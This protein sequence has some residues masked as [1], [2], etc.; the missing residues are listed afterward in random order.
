LSEAVHVE[1]PEQVEAR[2]GRAEGSVSSVEAEGTPDT[3]LEGVETSLEGAEEKEGNGD[4][5]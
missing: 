4:K 5:E 2:S 1:E 3:S